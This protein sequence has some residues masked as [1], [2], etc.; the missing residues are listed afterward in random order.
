MFGLA[1]L[2][3]ALRRPSAALHRWPSRAGFSLSVV[4]IDCDVSPAAGEWQATEAGVRSH[5]HECH[6]A[7]VPEDRNDAPHVAEALVVAQRWRAGASAVLVASPRD[8]RGQGSL[9]LAA[10]KITG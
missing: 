5:G 1:G 9:P 8:D 2:P 3:P 6:P 10:S 7:N 4:L